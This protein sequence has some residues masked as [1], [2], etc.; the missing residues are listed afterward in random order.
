V[1]SRLFAALFCSFALHLLASIIIHP[2]SFIRNAPRVKLTA[3]LKEAPVVNAPRAPSSEHKQPLEK[4][5]TPTSTSNT[6]PEE[7]SIADREKEAIKPFHLPFAGYYPSSELTDPPEPLGEV[8]PPNLD[9]YPETEPG[10]IVLTLWISDFGNV[11]YA[12][13]ESSTLPEAVS[14]VIVAGFEQLKFK[15]GEINGRQVGTI[16]RIEIDY[17]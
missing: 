17:R 11:V 2:G 13:R 6:S 3:L 1:R 7:A 16:L 14:N 12:L 15:P 10:K 4:A 9:K 5:S 8:D